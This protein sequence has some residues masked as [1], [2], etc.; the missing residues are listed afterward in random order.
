MTMDK[1]FTLVPQQ[2]NL[3]RRSASRKVTTGLVEFNGSLPLDLWQAHL[4]VDFLETGMGF[5][6]AEQTTVSF[7]SVSKQQQRCRH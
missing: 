3:W 4:Q 6:H 2:C 7:P 5:D 1:L